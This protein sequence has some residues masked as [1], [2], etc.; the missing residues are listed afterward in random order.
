MSVEEPH[1]RPLTVLWSLLETCSKSKYIKRLLLAAREACFLDRDST[2]LMHPRLT[3]ILIRLVPVTEHV[4]A[5]RDAPGI[6]C[7]GSRFQST[8]C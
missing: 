1:L 4:Q 5:P 3:E 8:A 7:W 2:T 6:S